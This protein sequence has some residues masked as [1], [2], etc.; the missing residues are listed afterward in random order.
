[1]LHE[2]MIPGG[3]RPDLRGEGAAAQTDDVIPATPSHDERLVAGRELVTAEILLEM[4]RF[5][6]AETRETDS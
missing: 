3:E 6:P 4:F 2:G 5:K 1:M